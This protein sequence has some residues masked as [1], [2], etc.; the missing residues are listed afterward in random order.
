MKVSFD[1][2]I[3]LLHV[4]YPTQV[5]LAQ[6][7]ARFQEHYENPELRGK[8][9]TL[10]ELREWYTNFHGAWTYYVDW[11]GFNFPS[12]VL[13]YFKD[14]SFD[15]LTALEE[16]FL[17][18]VRYRRGK[19]YI[20]G[21]YDGDDSTVKHEKLHALWYSN[22]AYKEEVQKYFSICFHLSPL[23]AHLRKKGYHEEVIEDEMQ[24]YLGA[25]HEY[26]QDQGLITTNCDMSPEAHLFTHALKIEEIANKYLEAQRGR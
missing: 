19:F 16:E 11:S 22:E 17:E 6:A 14:G 4:T 3:N 2:K 21:T 24:A 5:E 18:A 20:I 25:S 9:F 15:P 12:H 10:G 13:E 7:L 8:V 26:L 23:A 1:E